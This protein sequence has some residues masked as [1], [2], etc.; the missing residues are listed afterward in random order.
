MSDRNDIADRRVRRLRELAELG[1]EEARAVQKQ[2][3]AAKGSDIVALAAKFERA[4]RTVCRAIAEEAEIEQRR[5]QAL[6]LAQARVRAPR[7]RIPEPRSRTL[8]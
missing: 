7:P 2:M 8:H 4:A 5:Q 3:L 6:R 1:M